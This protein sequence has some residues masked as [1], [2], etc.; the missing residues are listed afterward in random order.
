MNNPE[1]AITIDMVCTST[2]IITYKGISELQ[3]LKVHTIPLFLARHYTDYSPE[4][5]YD[6]LKQY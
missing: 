1:A 3:H 5:F 2:K 4:T 6:K